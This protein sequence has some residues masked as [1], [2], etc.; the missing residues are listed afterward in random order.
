MFNV[1]CGG[2][3]TAAVAGELL[4]GDVQQHLRRQQ[5][6]AGGE[7][8]QLTHGEPAKGGLHL[9]LRQRQLTECSR[10]DAAFHGTGHVLPRLPQVG[11]QRFLHPPRLADA[12]Q[13]VIWQVV[14]GAGLIGVDSGHVPVAA[15]RSNALTQQL[16][17]TGKPLAQGGAVL[18]QMPGRV[19]QPRCRLAAGGLRPVGQQLGG[20]QHRQRPAVPD[21][22]L[23]GDVKIPHAVQL[24]VEELTPHA[25]FAVGGEHVQYA[26]PQGELSRALHLMAAD[27]TGGGKAIGQRRHIV[28]AAYL[29]RESGALQHVLWDAAL[30]HGVHGGHHHGAALRHAVQR[31]KA[32]ILPL[33]AVSGGA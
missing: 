19:L 1:R 11:A 9:S 18:F 4:G 24:V 30:G 15:R 29:Q 26:A 25:L 21:A 14:K 2:V 17:V 32:L 5:K 10:H 8:F 23:G 33:A 22:A 27:V 31:R 13:T 7:A 20:G 28:L 16:R 12:H 6:P 3:Q